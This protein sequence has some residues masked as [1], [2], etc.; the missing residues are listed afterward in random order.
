MAGVRVLTDPV[1]RPRVL[2]LRR[3]GKV[4]ASALRGVDAVLVSHLHYDHLDL[5]SLQRLGR[6]TPIVVPRGAG[7]LIRRKARFEHV[8][9]VSEGDTLEVGALTVTATAAEHD[10]GRLP[11]GAEAD[12]LGFV[13]RGPRSVY[14]AGDTDLFPGM[15]AIGPVDVA[16]VPIWGWGSGLGPGHMDPARAAESLQLLRPVAAI[17]IHW[18]TY[19]PAHAGLT[20]SPSFLDAPPE[21]FVTRVA[22]TAPEV[23]I[24]VL[25][26]G[27]S[28]VFDE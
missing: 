20:S 17:P 27:E 9:E 16:L 15:S 22:G 6:S 21:E 25:R 12:P 23:E 18:G 11:F 13:V 24:R 1:L 4:D 7:G 14:F 3:R 2:H 10:R 26:P 8:V 28:T 19:Y 5:P